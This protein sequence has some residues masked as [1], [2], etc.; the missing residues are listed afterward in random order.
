M[1]FSVIGIKEMHMISMEKKDFKEEEEC[2]EMIYFLLCSE[3]E[4]EADNN[5]DL[6]KEN[7][8]NTQ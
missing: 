4:W 5:K 8:C 6:K 1:K 7:Q 3:E 2:M